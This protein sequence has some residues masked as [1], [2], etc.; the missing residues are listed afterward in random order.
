MN[1]F[2][3]YDFT[4]V[5]APIL[6]AAFGLIMIY[7]SSMVTAIVEG[8]ESTYYLVKQ[9]QWFFVSLI[10]FVCVCLYPYKHF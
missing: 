2:K 8:R 3:Y 5:I 9:S 7:S 4:L 6:L 10:A 1:D